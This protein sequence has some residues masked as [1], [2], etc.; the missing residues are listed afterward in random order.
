[1]SRGFINLLG[2]LFTRAF[3]PGASE[4]K[5]T[6]LDTVS[7]STTRVTVVTPTSGKKI[8]IISCHSFTASTTGSAFEVYFDTGV[9]LAADR[10]KVIL[11]L[12]LD[13]DIQPNFGLVWP[14]GGGPVGDV[15]DV[16]SFRTGTNITTNGSVDIHY[17]EE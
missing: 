17:R 3:K 2:P 6:G 15:D 5:T 13:A 1:M 9:N 4:V 10:T 7:D 12:F 14:D 8:R 11:H 16:I